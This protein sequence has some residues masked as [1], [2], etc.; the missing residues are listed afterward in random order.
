M[1]KGFKEVPVSGGGSLCRMVLLLKLKG[2]KEAP[3]SRGGPSASESRQPVK[4]TS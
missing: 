3:M 1:L 2:L 4:L